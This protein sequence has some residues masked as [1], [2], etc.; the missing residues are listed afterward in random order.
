MR[1]YPQSR[2]IKLDSWAAVAAWALLVALFILLFA[3]LTGATSA[4]YLIV[5]GVLFV[6]AAIAHVLF[7]LTHKCPECS[8]HPTI[9]GFAQVRPDAE[10]R[11]KMDPW[12]RVV[13]D[14]VRRGRF[15]CM[16]CGTPYEISRAA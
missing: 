16:H 12:A 13:W 2:R 6:T 10:L 7:A 3:I 14:V 11:S 5:V 4:R 9:Q 15:T 8:K 1:T